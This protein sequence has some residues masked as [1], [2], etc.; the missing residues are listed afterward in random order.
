MLAARERA[1]RAHRQARRS[2]DDDRLT[3]LGLAGEAAYDAALLDHWLDGRT[4]LDARSRPGLPR[5]LLPRSLSPVVKPCPL[6]G[7]AYTG[8]T[9]RCA[10]RLCGD[11]GF[12][13]PTRISS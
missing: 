10:G 6:A 11:R 7:S 2:M 9:P 12:S 8:P 5:G 4:R 3:D 1:G 13:C